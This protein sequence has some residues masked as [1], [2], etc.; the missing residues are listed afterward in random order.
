MDDHSSLPS[1]VPKWCHKIVILFQIQSQHSQPSNPRCCTT[2]SAFG[3]QLSGSPSF[4]V[5]VACF[6]DF[7]IHASAFQFQPRSLHTS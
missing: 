7:L 3:G 1:F 4:P 2:D 5:E 6:A